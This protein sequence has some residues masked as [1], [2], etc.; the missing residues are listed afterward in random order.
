M[1]SDFSTRTAM[2]TLLLGCTLLACTDPVS[3]PEPVADADRSTIVKS[4]NDSRAYKAVTLNNGLEVLLVSDPAVEKSA[5]ALS[6]GV[7]LMF[8]PMD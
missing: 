1:T 3:S 2:L 8:D 7:G 6:V 5:A 4:S